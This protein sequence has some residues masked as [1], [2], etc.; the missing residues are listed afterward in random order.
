MSRI[1]SFYGIIIW[2]YWN[3]HRPPHFHATY[4]EFETLIKI[5]D[6]SIFSGFIPSRA[7]GL[8]IEWASQHREEL[9][10]NWELAEK[11]LPIKKI[12][13]LK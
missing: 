4:G 5:E 11:E 10:E 8:V 13:P 2:I 1:S 7:L 9:M 12:E 3:D 6:L